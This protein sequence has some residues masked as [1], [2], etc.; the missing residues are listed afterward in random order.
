MVDYNDALQHIL[1]AANIYAPNANVQASI[2]SMVADM[3]RD[4]VSP[5]DIGLQV[6]LCIADGYRYG[7]WPTK[8]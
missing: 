1:S 3:Q 7:N 5:S 6:I 8:E 2:A 4:N